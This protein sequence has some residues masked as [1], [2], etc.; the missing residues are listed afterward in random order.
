[1]LGE[2]VGVGVLEGVMLGEGVSVAV[3]EGVC[4]GVRV[5]VAVGVGDLVGVMEGVG[6]CVGEG[7]STDGLLVSTLP[8]VVFA[9]PSATLTPLLENRPVTKLLFTTET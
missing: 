3:C 5:L 2:G 4:V 9:L 6:V 8:N 1:M 7:G